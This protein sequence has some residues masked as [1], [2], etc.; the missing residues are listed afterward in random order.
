MVSLSTILSLSGMAA[1]IVAAPMDIVPGVFALEFDIHDR[2][3]DGKFSKRSGTYSESYRNKDQMFVAEV[4]IGSRKEKLSLQID[5]GSSDMWVPSAGTQGFTFGTFNA[6]KSKTLKTLK[7]QFLIQY[8]DYTYA[9]GNF[10][11]DTVL[12]GGKNVATLNSFQFAYVDDTNVTVS[13]L[14][15]IGLESSESTAYN[16]TGIDPSLEYVNFPIAMKNAG[17]ISSASYS[18]FMTSKRANSGTL[19]F[20]GKD[21][22]KIDGELVK[23]NHSGPSERLSVDL[24]S[25]VVG[26]KS[27]L[28]NEAMLLDSGTTLTYLPDAVWE[29]M[30]NVYGGTGDAD[31]NGLPY[32]D[33]GISGNFTF[34]FDGIT[35]DIPVTDFMTKDPRH[36]CA[37]AILPGEVILGDNF[38]QHVYAFYDLEDSSISL[39]NVKYSKKSNIVSA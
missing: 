23:L 31:D 36:L 8:G 6:A 16:G 21:L 18:L 12:F 3:V 24:K 39:G 7:E 5:T 38:L 11:E 35:I 37:L 20:G 22:A 10:V 13:G 29:D 28:V 19:L 1:T 14:L 26:G 34:A 9:S 27:I 25:I 30:M 33:C 4:R 32:V 2:Q 15:G 17:Y